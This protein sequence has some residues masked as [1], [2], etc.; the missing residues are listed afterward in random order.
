MRGEP[1]GVVLHDTNRDQLLTEPTRFLVLTPD[2]YRE[3]RLR[4]ARGILRDLPCDRVTSEA[5]D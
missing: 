2:G 1:E 5:C 3:L 4:V